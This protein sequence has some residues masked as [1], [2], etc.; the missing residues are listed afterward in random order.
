MVKTKVLKGA[1]CQGT[2]F[3]YQHCQPVI[4]FSGAADVACYHDLKQLG[5]LSGLIQS[6][7]KAMECPP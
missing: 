6:S 4:P 2:I 7:L 1:K 5:N 3:S